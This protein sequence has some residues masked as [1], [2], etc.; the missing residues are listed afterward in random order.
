[1]ACSVS[2]ED[3]EVWIPMM[4]NNALFT[5][6]RCHKD[7]PTADALF[8]PFCGAAISQPVPTTPEEVKKLLRKADETQDPKKKYAIL[9]EAEKQYPDSLDVAEALLFLGR[10]HERSSKKVDYSVIKCY[11]WHMYLTPGEFSAA[12]RNEMRQELIS[13]P[14]LLKCMSLAPDADAFLRHYLEKL[15]VE[16]VNLFLRGSNRYTNAFFGIRF[17]GRMAKVLASPV[18]TMLKNIHN[19][20][21]LPDD[22]RDMMYDAFYRAFLAGTGNDPKWIDDLLEKSGLPVPVKQ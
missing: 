7:I 3:E 5:C 15:G 9:S 19:D 21:Q 8:C 18:C 20:A 13:H 2:Y 10:L 4:Q 12:Q 11:L 22:K 1:M 16:F 6:P 14:Q 17:D